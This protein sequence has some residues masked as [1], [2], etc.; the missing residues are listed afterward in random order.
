MN[1]P[2]RCFQ[3]HE[4]RARPVLPIPSID[5]KGTLRQ[6]LTYTPLTQEQDMH[7][8]CPEHHSTP[9]QP[10]HPYCGSKIKIDLDNFKKE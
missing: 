3:H 9:S 4:S 7:V 6:I 2:N 8:E 5:F 1:S 10:T